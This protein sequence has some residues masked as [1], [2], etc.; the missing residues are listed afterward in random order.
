MLA[1]ADP[2]KVST[3]SVRGD[4]AFYHPNLAE[5][6]TESKAALDS[7]ILDEFNV[8]PSRLKIRPSI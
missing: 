2:N 5:M 3:K 7:I 6:I 1:M 8:R 4:L